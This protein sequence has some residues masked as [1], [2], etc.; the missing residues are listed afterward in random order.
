[1]FDFSAMRIINKTL[2]IGVLAINS[3]GANA[4]LTSYSSNGVDLVYS[5]VSDVT[6]TKEANLLGSMIVSYGFTSV[7]SNILTVSPRISN[8]PNYY[9]PAGTYTLTE[10]DFS[11]SG[12]ASW[13]GAMAYVNYLNS[14]KYGG[15]NQWYLPGVINTSFNY[16]STT[17]GTVPG[18]ELQELFYSELGGTAFNPI[19]NTANFN[20]E[21]SYYFWSGTEYL[22]RP[23][24]AWGFNNFYGIQYDTRKDGLFSVWAVTPGQISAVAEPQGA[25]MLFVGLGLIAFIACRRI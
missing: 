17:N 23:A 5:S 16:N 12:V 21:S 25:A 2:V 9:S 3:L 1:M 8:I 11:S 10:R 4:A 18:D 20:N 15:S 13:F 7:V 19:P 6:W 22:Q 14:I 24:S